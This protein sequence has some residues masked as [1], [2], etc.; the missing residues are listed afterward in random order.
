MKKYMLIINGK[1]AD[2]NKK[3]AQRVSSL[4]YMNNSYSTGGY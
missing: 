4:I 2:R 1:Q 3:A